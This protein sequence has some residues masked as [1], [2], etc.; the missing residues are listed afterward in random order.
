L[1]SGG[2][3]GSEAVLRLQPNLKNTLYHLHPYAESL[4]FFNLGVGVFGLIQV[5]T[6]TASHYYSPLAW[7]LKLSVSLCAL[8]IGWLLSGNRI[9]PTIKNYSSQ[10]GVMG[11]NY[12]ITL[13][14][15][16]DLIAWSSMIFGVWLILE[17]WVN[18]H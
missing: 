4:G 11:E 15:Q 6:T 1:L 12:W 16:N 9:N 8:S 14:E 18:M 7:L 3:V 5:I 17:P 2:I 13:S 10:I